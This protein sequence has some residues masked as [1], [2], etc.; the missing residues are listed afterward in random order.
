M[1][2][3]RELREALDD[4]V[5]ARSIPGLRERVLQ[6]TLAHKRRLRKERMA[7]RLRISLALVAAA[8]LVAV[9]VAAVMTWNSVHTNN[10]SQVGG[11]HLTAL[12]QLEARPFQLPAIG[13]G[14]ACPDHAGTNNYGFGYGDGPVYGDGGPV[15]VTPS[16]HFYDVSYYTDPGLKGPVLVRGK[17]LQSSTL[18]LV[19]VSAAG[20]GPVAGSDPTQNP[21]TLH[22]EFVLDPSNP[23]TR[24]GRFGKFPVRQ[25]IPTGW[26]G[27]FG[28]QIDGPSFTEMIYGFDSTYAATQSG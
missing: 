13:Q 7:F 20:S 4:V 6:T 26:R 2:V 21:P 25:G 17:D 8:L 10:V 19:F 1:S 23:P 27:C 5:P 14:A 11:V 12:E 28:I 18:R 22:T 15:I 16:G 24:Q 9:G 3:R